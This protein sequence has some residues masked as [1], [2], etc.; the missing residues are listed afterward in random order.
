[1]KFLV[2][3][4]IAMN[5]AFATT[6]EFFLPQTTVMSSTSGF[7]ELVPKMTIDIVNV[8]DKDA[9]IIVNRKYDYFKLRKISTRTEGEFKVTDYRT[10]IKSKTLVEQICDERETLRYELSFT[11]KV[12][13]YGTSIENVKLE[14]VLDY[15]YDWCHTP[16]EFE[17]FPYYLK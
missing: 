11:K 17:S 7:V 12:S 8:I 16:S 4:A 3:M 14:A 2:L 5:F 10:T 1:M 15:T 6:Y 9:S 13:E